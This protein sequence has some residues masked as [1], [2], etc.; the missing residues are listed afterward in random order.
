MSNNLLKENTIRRFMKLANVQGLT[1]NFIHEKYS[2]EDKEDEDE[3]KEEVN[4]Q[5]EPEMEEEDPE[6][7]VELDMEDEDCDQAYRVA[8][9]A[10]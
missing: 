4:E 5:E 6:A 8:C 1:D 10:P 9:C 3:K 7:D 2:R